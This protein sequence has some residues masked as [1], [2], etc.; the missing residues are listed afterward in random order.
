MSRE[1]PFFRWF[2]KDYSGDALVRSMTRD[3]DLAYRRLLDQSWE[4]G[5]LPNDKAKLAQLCGFS[6]L[7]FQAIWSFPLVDC[8]VENGDGNLINNRLEDERELA[9]KKSRGAAKAARVKW[10]NRRKR[11][12]IKEKP[13]DATAQ[14]PQCG[15]DAN[16]NNKNKDNKSKDLTKKSSVFTDTPVLEKQRHLP[17]PIPKKQTT[18]KKPT[19]DIRWIPGIRKFTGDLGGLQEKVK[20]R[21]EVEFGKKWINATWYAICEWCE[22]NQ[23][24]IMK[25]TNHSMFILGWFRRD[26]EKRRNE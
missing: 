20:N 10:R 5:S 12:G 6:P 11:M 22:D 14:R 7:E 19:S 23:D 21:Y 3:Q 8:W 16:N 4:L 1:F 25:K 18:K 2:P 26:A 13:P 24:K 17:V 9:R 15:S